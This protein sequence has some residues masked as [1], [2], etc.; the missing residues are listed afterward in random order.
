MRIL[1][2]TLILCSLAIP[3]AAVAERKAP[4]W[5]SISAGKAR[6]RSGPGRQFPATWMYQRVGLPVKVLEIY[7]NWRKIQDP[8]GTTGWVQG[9][10]LSDNRTAIVTGGIREMRAA[11]AAGASVVWRAEPGVIGLL[12]QC[13]RGWCLFDVKGHNGYI[14]IAHIWGAAADERLP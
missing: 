2:H 12:K 9:N 5:A 1:I 14:E 6:M 8:D 4:Y 7:P 3:G 11:A 13:D 10:L